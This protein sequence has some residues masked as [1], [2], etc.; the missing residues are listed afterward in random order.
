[1]AACPECPLRSRYS[2]GSRGHTPGEGLDA[3]ILRLGGPNFHCPADGLAAST[4]IGAYLSLQ[5]PVRSLTPPFSSA[6]LL[7][8]R[9][10]GGQCA[11]VQWL[12][13][14]LRMETRDYALTV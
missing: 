5:M 4:L 6:Y 8:K 14:S 13:H 1:M 12:S 11:H 10:R 2:P 3:I 9:V 7:P